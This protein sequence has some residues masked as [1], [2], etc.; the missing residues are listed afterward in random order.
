MSKSGARI[1]APTKP[2]VKVPSVKMVPRPRYIRVSDGKIVRTRELIRNCILADFDEAG[3]V[4]GIEILALLP[5]TRRISK[6]VNRK[7]GSHVRPK[8]A[9][10]KSPPVVSSEDR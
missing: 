10:A 8:R 9:P 2:E 1:S 6:R 5:T 7:T 4:V 3:N